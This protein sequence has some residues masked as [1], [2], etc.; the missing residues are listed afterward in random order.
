MSKRIFID[1]FQ[2]AAPQ[3]FVNF[4]TGL[5]NYVTQSVYF[6]RIPIIGGSDRS[7]FSINE[8]E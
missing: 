3:K 1:P 8:L 7:N 5:T 4:E 6:G 2:M